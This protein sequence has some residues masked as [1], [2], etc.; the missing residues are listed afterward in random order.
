MPA[1]RGGRP[2]ITRR[3]VNSVHSP[4][5]QGPTP[6]RQNLGQAACPTGPGRRRH[7]HNQDTRDA[8]QGNLCQLKAS[9]ASR[10]EAL[11]GCDDVHGVAR[12]AKRPAGLGRDVARGGRVKA[13]RH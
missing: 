13:A 9:R 2:H 6:A 10:L 3:K 7:R 12:A 11:G 5:K 4:S 8:R 1:R